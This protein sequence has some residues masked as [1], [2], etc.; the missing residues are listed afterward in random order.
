MTAASISAAPLTIT[1]QPNTKVY[2]A[3]TS[4]AVSPMATGSMPGD[5]VTGL[6]EIYD[7]PNAG[8]GKTLSVSGY[9]VNDGNGGHNYAVTTLVN[10]SG[11]ISQADQLIVWSNP[12]NVT[13]GT[14]LSATQLNATVSGVPGGSAP[15]GLTYTPAAGAILPAG[16]NTL[17]VDAA[18][19][20]NYKAAGKTVSVNVVYSVGTCLGQPGHQILQPINADGTSVV[21]KGST[22]PAKF[23]VC[24]AAGNSVGT[25]GVVSSFQLIQVINGTVIDNVTEDPL[26]T[27][28]DAAFRWDATDRQW[29]FNISTKNLT[30]NKTYK[31]EIKLND[32]GSIVFQFGTK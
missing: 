23:R 7:T 20:V 26:S 12:T 21:K 5:T 8:S 18:G 15:G 10:A 6:A 13:F 32:G 19:T 11:V 1:A 16:S 24:D 4:A 2:D 25:P 17:N 22:V 30:A 31:Y 9:T 3:T 14:P 27:T 28:P 29:I